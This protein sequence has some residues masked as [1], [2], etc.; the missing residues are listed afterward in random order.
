MDRRL[1]AQL[2]MESSDINYD[3]FAL[4]GISHWARSED[5]SMH[6]R[7]QGNQLVTSTQKEELLLSQSSKKVISTYFDSKTLRHA[8]SS[9]ARKLT[10]LNVEERHA[11][12][13]SLRISQECCHPKACGR[14]SIGC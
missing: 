10:N 9:S 11:L 14:H 12:N 5:N 3:K 7:P 13:V 8:A 6:L 2:N 1:S 4:W